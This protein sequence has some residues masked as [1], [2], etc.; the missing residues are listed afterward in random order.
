MMFPPADPW[1]SAQPWA[2]PPRKPPRSRSRLVI[3]VIVLVFVL[4]ALVVIVA[5]VL[6]LL[7]GSDGE[8]I[9]KESAL[10]GV[11]LT[12]PEAGTVL[13]TGPL[14]AE[15]DYDG[16]VEN[17]WNTTGEGDDS[18]N[19][20]AGA[21]H[22]HKDSRAAAVRVQHLQSSDAATGQ[23]K[24]FYLTQAVVAYPDADAAQRYVQNAKGRWQRC[25][26]KTFHVARSPDAA[27]DSRDGTNWRNGDVSDSNGILSWPNTETDPDANG[28]T[29]HK[30]IAPL[31]NVVIEIEEC[32]G[33]AD[34]E[35]VAP[36]ISKISEKIAKAAQPERSSHHHFHFFHHRKL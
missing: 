8:R 33:V 6:W 34:P 31:D 27:A 14:V 18:C 10:T 32:D 36:L 25:V 4:M 16:N 30:A 12:K 20:S 19:F 24:E 2:P 23:G 5:L 28:W 11:L 22:D 15:S 9:V 21:E 26:G 29:C 7:G 1:P 35:F 3:A 13:G 17:S